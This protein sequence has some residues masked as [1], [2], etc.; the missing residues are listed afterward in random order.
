MRLRP[1]RLI[2]ES[3]PSGVAPYNFFTKRVSY[4]PIGLTWKAKG[5]TWVSLLDAQHRK[6]HQESE[7]DEPGERVEPW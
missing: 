6:L 1:V 2:S 5:L 7:M 3:L 4:K